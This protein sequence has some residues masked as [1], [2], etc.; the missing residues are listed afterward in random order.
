MVAVVGGPAEGQLTEVA[1]ADHETA[2]AVGEIHQLERAHAR[3]PIFIGHIPHG[4]VLTDVAEVAADGVRDRDFP[5]GD[6]KLLTQNFG[7]GARPVRGAEAGH[8]H[9]EDVRHGTAKLFHR[10]DGGQQR[11]AAVQTSGDADDGG[12]RVG[13]LEPLCK[14]VCLNFQNQLAALR[15]RGVAARD[16]GRRR[17]PA[18]QRD[19]AER[20]IKFDARVAVRRRL[21]AGAAAAFRCQPPK[22]QLRAGASVAEGAA[23]RQQ[24]TVFAD[25]IVRGKDH[26]GGGFAVAG[27]G[28]E[29]GAQEP[30][31]LL[32]DE[33]TA[34]FGLSGGL[35]AGGKIHNDGR[36]GQCVR[37]ARRQRRP[38]ILAD[39]RRQHEFRHGAAAE[40]QLRAEQ[41]LLPGEAD[42]PDAGWR[43]GEVAALIEFAVVRNVGFRN[44][45]EQPP[46][47]DDGRAVV[48]L[49]VHI[50]RQADGGDQRQ[51]LAGL[52]NGA[53]RFFGGPLQRLLQKQVAACVAGEAKLGENGE[54][55]AVRSGLTH[56]FDGH[57]CVIGTVCDPQRRR[58]R[59]DPEKSVYH[60]CSILFLCLWRRAEPLPPDSFIIT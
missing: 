15:A 52:Q 36:A 10:A 55:R 37:R 51:R 7:I 60:G 44:E 4:L 20:Q 54:L 13:V 26:V 38:E 8:G 57:F 9:G 46:A 40:Q 33:L 32:R 45:A 22:I 59:A 39:L 30:R 43:G 16:E 12:F 21:K 48:E 18:R 58:E 27:V 42:A 35:V 50:D 29:I 49:A 17:K 47:A 41:R 23:F 28:I 6:A 3:L 31:G 53:E 5:E 14:A 24:R 11:K 56:G 1:R 2:G 34:I 19:R 25:E